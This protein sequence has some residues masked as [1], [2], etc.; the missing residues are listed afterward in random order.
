MKE[1]TKIRT[2]WAREEQKPHNMIV[3]KFDR[4]EFELLQNIEWTFTEKVD[5]TNIRIMW[6]GNKVTFGGKTDNAQIPAKLIEKLYE[7]FGGENNEQVFESVFGSDPVCLYGEGYGGNIQGLSEYGDF[8]FILFDVKVGDWWVER[9]N[10]EDIAKK[11]DISVVPI[12]AKGTLHEM[13]ELVANGFTS[14][15]GEL[16][17]EGLVARP[18]T[19]LCNRKGE[20][21]ITKLK[22]KD[23]VK[24][25]NCG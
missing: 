25:Q 20:R 10:I 7:L 15:L 24:L 23:F 22:H 8:N 4:P 18:S 2:L 13:S 6:D 12:I 5:G 11:F 14:T 16:K 21:I 19:E 17:S 1:Y 9:E 3:G